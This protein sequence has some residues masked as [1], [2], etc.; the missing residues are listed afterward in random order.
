LLSREDGQPLFLV[1]DGEPSPSHHFITAAEEY[2]NTH[3]RLE[4]TSL[5]ELFKRFC[6][7][8]LVFRL[9]W[10]SDKPKAKYWQC[11]TLEEVTTLVK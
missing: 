8:E 1:H 9:W 4:G 5:F 11:S 10:A 2:F 6:D 3:D 7:E